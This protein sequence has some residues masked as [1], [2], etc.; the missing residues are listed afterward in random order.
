MMF[1]SNKGFALAI[2]G[3]A[4]THLTCVFFACHEVVA[5]NLKLSSLGPIRT[6]SPTNVIPEGPVSKLRYDDELEQWCIHNFDEDMDIVQSQDEQLGDEASLRDEAEI[7]AARK[8][9]HLKEEEARR[10]SCCLKSATAAACAAFV[11]SVASGPLAAGFGA[12]AVGQAVKIG[13]HPENDPDRIKKR[14]ELEI[15][16]RRL[17]RYTRP[18]VTV[19]ASS[20]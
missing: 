7:L 16:E 8:A 4:A 20:K 3:G 11:F 2:C 15:L 5:L 10:R 1:T 17:K 14:M 12:L 6:V 19:P 9:K 18:V 13:A